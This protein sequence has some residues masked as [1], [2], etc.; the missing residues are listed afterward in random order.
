[1]IFPLFAAAQKADYRLYTVADGLPF[2]G[3]F[4]IAQDTQGFV[5]VNAGEQLGRFD[6]QKFISRTNSKHPVFDKATSVPPWMVQSGANIHYGDQHNFYTLNTLTGAESIIP[7]ANRLLPGRWNNGRSVKLADNELAI[8]FTEENEVELLVVLLKGGQMTGQ[9]K[10]EGVN[11][12][13]TN[14]FNTFCTDGRSHFYFIN[15]DYTN[16]LKVDRRGKKTG[17]Y[18]LPGNIK[19]SNLARLATGREGAVLFSI[20]YEVFKLEQGATGFLPHPINQFLDKA[21]TGIFDLLETPEGDLW[22]CGFNRLVA[23]FDLKK[24]VFQEFTSEIKQVIPYEVIF[25]LLYQDSHGSI[26]LGSTLGLLRVTPESTYFETYFTAPSPDCGGFCSFRGFAEDEQGSVYASFYNNIFKIGKGGTLANTPLLPISNG[27]FDIYFEQGKLLLNNGRIFN[28]EQGRFANEPLTSGDFG[29]IA[30]DGKGQLWLALGKD[31]YRLGEQGGKLDWQPIKSFSIE[32]NFFNDIAYDPANRQLW[33]ATNDSLWTFDPYNYA[34]HRFGEKDVSFPSRIKCIY[35]DGIGSLWLGTER[36][37]VHF[38]YKK[39][40]LRNYTH[41]DGLS[42]DVVVGIL[43]EGDSCLWVSTYNGLSRYSM[44]N[45][46]FLNFHKQDGLA[47][48]EFNRASYFKAS[49]GHM[50]YGGVRGVTAFYPERLMAAFARRKTRDRLLLRGITLT[51]EGSDS[52]FTLLF[53]NSGQPLHAYHRNR[54]IRFDFGLI[55]TRGSILFSYKLDGLNENWSTPTKDNG[56]T[57]NSLPAGEYVFRVKAMD[58]RGSW[59]PDEIAV[60][61][62]VHPPWWATWWA[63]LIYLVLLASIAYGIFY[64]LKKRW[65][66]Q[67]QLRLE[68]QEAV[69]LKEL[70]SFK[71]QLFTNITHEFRTPLTVILGMAEQGNL[72]IGKL[73][74]LEIGDSTERFQTISNFLI[75][76]FQLIERNGQNLLRLINQLLDLS[77]L[78]NKTFQL[79]LQHGDIVP[80]LRYLTESFHSYANVR[81]QSLRFF[82][83]LEQLEMDYDAEQLYQIMGNLLSNALKFTPSGG[84]IKVE[85]KKLENSKIGASPISQFPNFLISVSD[86]GIGIPESEMPHVFDRFYQV[87]GT[88][89]RPGEGTGIGLAHTYELVKLMKGE[90]EVESQL[91]VGSTFTVRLPITHT[92]S[93]IAN[94]SPETTPPK[95]KAYDDLRQSIDPVE[96]PTA[97]VDSP[98]S[99]IQSFKPSILIMEDNPD[100]VYYLKSILGEMYE[101]DIAYNGRVGVEKALETIPDLVISDVMMPEKD[102]FQVLDTLKNEERTSHIPILLLTAKGDVASKLSGL[103]R[104]ADAYLPKPFERAEMLVTLEMMLANRRRMGNYLGRLQGMVLMPT[105]SMSATVEASEDLLE[106]LASTDIE[107]ENAFLQR[108]RQVVESN[109]ADDGFAL[110]QLCHKLGMSRS[111]LFRKM[112]ALTNVSPSDYIRD[113]RMKQAKVLLETKKMTVKE[114]AYSVGFKD[115]PHFSRTYQET[116]GVSPSATNK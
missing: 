2:N 84:E 53:P 115:I 79:H 85:I 75:S 28:L 74:K 6:G 81:N 67:G 44:A 77:K 33:L 108:V 22:I 37:L 18:S 78:E 57:F 13:Q 82:S 48:N 17:T 31:L 45:G 86:T 107:I 11:A 38:D 14:Y 41:S 76:N 12:K 34:L 58:A 16:V 52:T 114:V 24:G 111:Q 39:S 27:P 93:Q 23:H 70:D 61:L 64:F 109:Y 73:K 25:N 63:Y 110:P 21:T 102:G 20:E 104:G 101:L 15:S 71:S 42:N 87:D 98:Q 95:I 8:V 68:Q 105:A 5:W 113:F 50:F 7:L 97:V 3:I 89:T 40:I 10:L 116:H 106:E 55:S 112:K 83:T 88:S 80:Y 90:I 59:L 32:R 43:P 49:D 103:R 56:L 46:R 47:D 100:V 91:G 69:R 92:A 9:F 26:W 96:T 35:P 1:M 51:E 4:G 66:L 99:A 30:R 62:I 19:P 65:E 60:P 54:T 29:S 36:G 72:E 94:N